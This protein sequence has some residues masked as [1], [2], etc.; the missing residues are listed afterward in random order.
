LFGLHQ[1]RAATMQENLFRVQ[2]ILFAAEFLPAL[3]YW[4]EF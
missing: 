4:N 2:Y 3:I 1:E